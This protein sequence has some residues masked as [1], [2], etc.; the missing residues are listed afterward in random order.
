MTQQGTV[1]W[2][3]EISEEIDME[4]RKYEESHRPHTVPDITMRK[5]LRRIARSLVTSVITS[6]IV[7][8]LVSENRISSQ[9]V[10]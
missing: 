9:Q 3:S 2:R 4:R 1:N 6:A 8:V 10:D 7:T 5:Q